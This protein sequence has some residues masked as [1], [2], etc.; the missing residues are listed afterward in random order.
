MV[1][2]ESGSSLNPAYAEW[3]VKDQKLIGVLLA[4]LT[5]MAMAEVIGCTTAR[6]AW[7]ALEAAFSYSS[8]SRVNQ[9]REKLL[10]LKKGSLTV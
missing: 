9:L 2:S 1:T 7:L 10:F 8:E 5:K 3:R 4:S 6:A